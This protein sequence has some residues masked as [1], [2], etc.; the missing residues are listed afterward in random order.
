VTFSD[1]ATENCDQSTLTYTWTFSDSTTPASGQSVTHQYSAAGTYN[2]S[3]TVTDSVTNATVSTASY[4]ITVTGAVI[5][6]ASAL[7]VTSASATQI[8][9]SWTGSNASSYN[10]Y[11][12]SNGGAHFI[13]I[14]SCVSTSYTDSLVTAGSTYEYYVV[15]TGTCGGGSQSNTVTVEATAT[16]LS[17]VS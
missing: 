11:R 5:P 8:T 3:L 7:T 6:T 15:P 16:Q 1:V 14:D 4:S 10:I 2:Y 12:S 17:M 9:L 13:A